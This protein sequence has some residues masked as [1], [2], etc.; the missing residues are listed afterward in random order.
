MK[1]PKK[2]FAVAEA[3]LT[4]SGGCWKSFRIL[5]KTQ[6]APDGTGAVLKS[7]AIAAVP[8]SGVNA[9]VTALFG[10]FQ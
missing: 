8:D 10:G 7:T 4:F 3:M 9:F 5:K 2:F 6:H 1:L